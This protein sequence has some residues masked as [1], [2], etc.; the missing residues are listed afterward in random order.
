MKSTTCNVSCHFNRH[1]IFIFYKEICSN[2]FYCRWHICYLHIKRLLSHNIE[3][4][5][6]IFFVTGLEGSHLKYTETIN[7]ALY[8]MYGKMMNY[9]P[10]FPTWEHSKQ[11]PAQ[12]S[13]VFCPHFWHK[14]TFG[15][16][17]CGY[18]LV[19][20]SNYC[21]SDTEV[22]H[23]R[24]HRRRFLIDFVV[25]FRVKKMVNLN[26]ETGMLYIRHL[27]GTLDSHYNCSASM[28]RLQY[29]HIP[30]QCVCPHYHRVHIPHSNIQIACFPHCI[31]PL[32]TVFSQ[33]Q[34]MIW[35]W[36]QIVWPNMFW[37]SD[38]VERHSRFAHWIG[39]TLRGRGWS[40][41]WNAVINWL[42]DWYIDWSC[43]WLILIDYM[44][45]ITSAI[46][47]II[48]CCA[49][50]S[51]IIVISFTIITVCLTTVPTSILNLSGVG[52]LFISNQLSRNFAIF[53][54]Q[55]CFQQAIRVSLQSSD[56]QHC[57][58]LNRINLRI[59]TLKCYVI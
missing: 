40:Y 15:R 5:N 50:I 47:C 9:I 32:S 49:C 48:M 26:V 34:H 16:S 51:H 27:D 25:V 14:H 29:S 18:I 59:H 21:I 12:L 7:S 30:Y 24:N 13:H 37:L 52:F 28:Y 38:N 1:F 53:I 33:W 23:H 57:L 20:E 11:Q 56:P 8:F 31:P 2:E 58:V 45:Y 43:Y 44:S 54:L 17:F 19:S 4:I 41:M 6:F 36:N 3:T 55:S 46:H 35:M 10:H 42:I 22:L 39:G